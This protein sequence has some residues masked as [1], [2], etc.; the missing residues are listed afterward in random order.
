MDYVKELLNQVIRDLYGTDVDCEVTRPDEQL[1]DY[2]TNVALRLAKPLKK[3]PQA[4]AEQII[5][6]LKKMTTT[7]PIQASMAGPGFINL[8]LNAQHL[9]AQLLTK[10]ASAPDGIYGASDIGKGKLVINEFP[11]PNMAK[12]FSVGHI[13]AAL[14]GWAIYKLML[15]MGY[16]TIRDNH[17]G[18]YG[19][20]F[21]KWVVGFLRY[22]SEQ[23]LE[24]DGIYELARVYIKITT[25]LKAESGR[26]ET[27]IAEE[28]Q[29]WLIR[30]D[31]NDEQ[32]VSYSQRFNKISLKHMHK[33]MTRLNVETDIELGESFFV[34]RAQVLVNEL[35]EDNLAIKSDGAV[36]VPL[37][38]YQID[39]PVMLRKANGAALY[40]TTD[41]ATIEFRQN[42]WHP[43]KV[44]IHTGQEQAFYFRQLQALAKKV[45][46]EDS[47]VHLWHGIVD[48]LDDDG[49]RQKMSSRKGVVLLDD[50][51]DV[52]EERAQ[53]QMKTASKADIQ[54]VALAAIKFAD[55]A[56]DR[57]KGL[58]FDWDTM[59]NLQGFS[60]PAV[61]YAAVRIASVLKKADSKDLHQAPESDYDWVAEKRLLIHLL[62]FPE[63]LLNLHQ[64]YEMHKLASYLYDLSRELNRY[65]EK[66]RVLDSPPQIQAARLWLLGVTYEVFKNGLDIL[67][68][69]IPDEM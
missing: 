13:R 58:L 68:I 22:S 3:N 60:G 47:I 56:A 50:L 1:G 48:Q 53:Q 2:A 7:Q 18:D 11:S 5:A 23:Q 40:T 28:V 49:Q 10:L 26:Q 29:S 20:P 9:Q 8:T 39:T 57:K 14:Q 35:L 54:A 38:E 37:D 43:D 27:A 16:T 41:L 4:I 45:G 34:D 17:L 36:I 51:L 63:L 6:E 64:T 66:H 65:Y 59:F 42:N 24:R 33:V 25:E 62:E 31:N 32:A 46:L 12:P 15:M 55:F 44:F 21:G 52:A 30:L 19:T 61:Q 67:G 69:A